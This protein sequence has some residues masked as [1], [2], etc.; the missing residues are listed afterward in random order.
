MAD[1][2]VGTGSGALP[3]AESGLRVG[4]LGGVRAWAAGG[5]PVALGGSGRRAALA[6]LALDAGRVVSAARLVDGLYG[7]HPPAGVANAVQSQIS[8]LRAALR[9]PGGPDPIEHRPAGYRLV[10]DPD[11]VDVHRF[12]RLAAQG[13]QAL[14]TGDL[15]KAGQTLE[16]ALA[17]WRGPALADVRDVPFAQ[18]QAV[19]LEDL[20]LTAAEDLAQARI[21]LGRR[22]EAIAQLREL[23][24]AEP[25]RERLSTLL[26]LAL[27]ADGR[28]AEALAAFGEARS[29]LAEALGA[30]PGPQLAAAHLA[31][32]R[33]DEVRIGGDA[34]TADGSR[35]AGEP[36]IEIGRTARRDEP[37]AP[38]LRRL[39]LPAPLNELIGRAPDLDRIG[40]LLRR[41]RLLTLT[42]PGGAGKT[43]IAVEAAGRHPQDSCFAD[44]SGLTEGED[45][46]QA[47]LSALGLR[48]SA[49]LGPA[50]G[51][52]PLARLANA[53]RDRPLLLVLDNCEHLVAQCARFAADLLAA[54]PDLRVLATS[55]EALGITGEVVFSLPPL[56]EPAAL[57]LFA[58]RAAAARPDFDPGRD[59]AAAAEI[60]GR[61]DGLPLAI[62][63]AAARLRLLT[64]RQ[65]ADRL[66]DRFRLLTGGARTA[67]PR[68][69]TLR[70]VVDWSWELL[71]G[72]E[73]AV[74]R[75][76]SVFSGGFTLA[77]GEAVCADP[78]AGAG[79]DGS[80]G[81]EDGS[82]V[83]RADVLDLL[84][85]LVDKSLVMAVQPQ[86]A[87]E[88]QAGGEIRFRMLQTVRAYAAERLAE[89]GEAARI[90][91]SHLDVFLTLA[92]HANP[93]LRT[94]DQLHWLSRLAADHDNLLAALR[95][96]DPRTAL[97][98]ISELA[99]YWLL[100][101]LRFEA[102]PHARRVL[103]ALGPQPLP[104]LAEEYAIC[105]ALAIQSA[106]NRAELAD[107]IAAAEGLMAEFW[108]T[109]RR[110]P[111]L[112][113]L[114]APLSGVREDMVHVTPQ[115]QA[116][117][118]ADPW[119][120]GLAH[121][122]QGYVHWYVTGDW[123]TADREFTEAIAVYRRLGDRW[124]S[125]V[126]LSEAAAIADTLGDRDRSQARTAEAL[127][128][129]GELG[130]TEDTAELLCGRAERAVRV[131]ELAAAE[132]DCERAIVLFQQVGS[133]ESVPRARLCL[134]RIDRLRGDLAAAR[135]QCLIALAGSPAPDW[136]GA[137]WLRYFAMVELARVDQA[138]DDLAAARARYRE[139]LP[140]DVGP[141]NLPALALGAEALAGL[142]L[143]EGDPEQAAYL[144]GVALALRHSAGP[145]DV[146]QRTL[147]AA[148]RA[149]LGG[150][151]GCAPAPM[152]ADLS[153]G[154]YEQVHARGA[155]LRPDEAIAA[156]TA[157]AQ[158]SPSTQR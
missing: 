3:G 109:P 61:L 58:E 84:G 80:G 1:E 8:R 85:S 7:A 110:N 126:A 156:L 14:R 66:D 149:A 90:D 135:E 38:G 103:A 22:R 137:T 151:A 121:I 89:S 154:R 116:A 100:R 92:A 44:L 64:P 52:A 78:A 87:A 77:A 138:G 128:L 86:S 93:L 105:V 129:A 42:G 45:V 41:G 82:R 155:A 120:E 15:A 147:T 21:R 139:A 73:R 9:E 98:M 10:V 79:G 33:G 26:V 27:H 83:E 140:H 50:D 28:Q 131:G 88:D 36:T 55:R 106:A 35:G 67:R 25:L 60:C 37:A 102:T 49:L 118:L 91:Q 108:R 20:R 152:S 29:A 99:S 158:Q 69:Q 56:P 115:E 46:S 130:A 142:T 150:D 122:G 18:A 94:A 127:R 48:G 112:T 123:A 24:A 54:C 125:I 23:V 107:H 76:A 65:V 101:G 144:Q 40:V 53:L 47:V 30:D 132:A 75:R 34:D 113:L 43:R 13:H 63:L 146:E 70:A 19:R 97:R 117:W 74:L 114:W 57:R 32:L 31:V 11:R 51:P 62:E 4:I 136:F 81:D 153:A 95:R 104:G 59:P 111:V 119:H 71:S 68:Q 72:P 143:A 96:S 141:R 6:L 2:M 16:D 145:Q 12:T 5:D 39:A 124:G 134:A 157:A 148:I 133:V 17:L